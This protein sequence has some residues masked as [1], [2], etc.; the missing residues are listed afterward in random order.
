MEKL[1]E[2]FVAGSSG[3]LAYRLLSDN[4]VSQEIREAYEK[5]NQKI[6]KEENSLK[7]SVKAV[8]ESLEG[9]AKDLN[10]KAGVSKFKVWK[11]PISRFGNR[12]GNGR[13]YTRELWENVINNQQDTWKGA[14]GLMDHPT[15]DDDGSL[16]HS[17]IV[18]YDME[19]DDANQVIWGVGSF[20]GIYGHQVA[21][22]II[23]H[24]GKIGFS[25]SGFGDVMADGTVANYI[26]E[27]PA[28]IVLNPSQNVYG[29]V[30]DPAIDNQN[31]T[32]TKQQPVAPTS[33]QE[34]SSSMT[35]NIKESVEANKPTEQPT[36]LT[37]SSNALAFASAK[38]FV[39]RQIDE[40]NKIENPTEK[41]EAAYKLR[42]FVQE[43]LDDKETSEKLDALLKESQLE[44]EQ[45]V[46]KLMDLKEQLNGQDL[47]SAI[48]DGATAKS[49]LA[50]F[51]SSTN[52]LKE[53]A[54]VLAKRLNAAK[55]EN[56]RLNRK[57]EYARHANDLKDERFKTTVRE[58][59]AKS[60]KEK[61]A[62]V[63]RMLIE[64]KKIQKR[65]SVAESRLTLAK[66]NLRKANATITKL[67]E[68]N[69]NLASSISSLKKQ[70]AEANKKIVSLTSLSES[71]KKLADTAKAAN[72]RL[73]KALQE[74]SNVYSDMSELQEDTSDYRK[75]LDNGN[76]VD[77]FYKGLYEKY[78]D[79]VL[80]FEKE[81]RESAN[82]S[83]AFN[84]FLKYRNLIDSR[85]ANGM[86]N[87]DASITGI[88]RTSLLRKS[89]KSDEE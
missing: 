73:E 26:I 70:L 39:D 3:K 24:G 74:S 41:L 52:S 19:I 48:K 76:E 69:N 6:L 17:A 77:A 38:D 33:N 78:G 21:E 84:K 11:F 37:E 55:A 5:V 2:S 63:N 42:A 16:K 57:L 1:V 43:N 7:S 34:T 15:G 10:D 75:V 31:I 58:D 59:A 4:E 13:I 35:E 89:M 29:S 60:N 72:D 87:P 46:A 32:Y 64:A 79:H 68:D 45:S 23:L 22:D 88:K 61:K 12:N 28:D 49:V 14:V 83:D 81:I 86:N 18:W 9:T 25:S 54:T 20:V 56:E 47:D 80:P 67:R 65:Q 27:R 51:S 36:K 71:N 50:K 44:I 8:K 30:D 82:Y 53:A 62:L 40:C 85:F 66:S